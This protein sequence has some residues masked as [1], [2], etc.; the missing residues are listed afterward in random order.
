MRLKK[1][2]AQPLKAIV[3]IVKLKNIYF[4][5]AFLMCTKTGEFFRIVNCSLFHSMQLT[6][7]NVFSPSLSRAYHFYDRYFLLLG[8]E[9]LTASD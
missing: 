4:P 5:N 9:S 8:C 6:T 3:I 7:E 1:K 2:Y